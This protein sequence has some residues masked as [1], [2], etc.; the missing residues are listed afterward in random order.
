MSEFVFMKEVLAAFGRGATRLFRC[1]AG[2][3][4]QGLEVEHT[5]TRIVLDKPRAVHGWPPGT[6]DLVGWQSVVITPQMVGQRVALFVAVETK[7][8]AG[9]LTRGQRRFL[10]AVRAA[11][12]L[13]VAARTLAGVAAVLGPAGGGS[14]P[15]LRPVRPRP[16]IDGY[17]RAA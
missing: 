13:A 4:W 1:N 12:G 16:V 3:S 7:S 11:G 2:V 15:P 8:P 6:A 14:S 5:R 10:T 9:R 17:R